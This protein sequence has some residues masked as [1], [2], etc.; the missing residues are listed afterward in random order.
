MP[1]FAYKAKRNPASDDR[2]QN[3]SSTY[4][5]SV[6]SAAS[7]TGDNSF[8]DPLVAW[9]QCF[10]SLFLWWRHSNSQHLVAKV[11]SD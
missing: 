5:S 3:T 1:W 4:Q 8:N 2:Q 10:N 11:V 7:R 6:K 9:K